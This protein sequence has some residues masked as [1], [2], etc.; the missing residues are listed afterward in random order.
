MAILSD[1]GR[2]IFGADDVE[3]ELRVPEKRDRAA[4]TVDY[5]ETAWGQL[6]QHTNVGDLKEK[7]ENAS[8]EIS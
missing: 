1:D 3:A 6:L 5:W 7:Y 8:S 2:F 4:H